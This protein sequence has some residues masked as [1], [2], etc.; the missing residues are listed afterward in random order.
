MLGLDVLLAKVFYVSATG[1]VYGASL[2]SFSLLDDARR[3]PRGGRTLPRALGGLAVAAREGAF[4]SRVLAVGMAAAGAASLLQHGLHAPH[5]LHRLPFPAADD[6]A[7]TWAGAA[8][9]LLAALPP[10]AVPGRALRA[11]CAATGATAL[12]CALLLFSPAE[13]REAQQ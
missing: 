6:R 8:A 11:T 10:E 13:A 4:T 9:A 5:R 12:T 2:S 3:G 1:F 7:S